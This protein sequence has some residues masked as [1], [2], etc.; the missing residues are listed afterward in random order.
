MTGY[1]VSCATYATA[2]KHS[3]SR[4]LGY[5]MDTSMK[6]NPFKR[7]FSFE[8]SYSPNLLRY[9]KRPLFNVLVLHNLLDIS[10]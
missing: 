1:I 3:T 9:M 10:K 8:V 7:A 5:A 6:Y 2:L 4:D